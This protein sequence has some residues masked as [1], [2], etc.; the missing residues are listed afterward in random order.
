MEKKSK[1]L[2]RLLV[3]GFLCTPLF[4]AGRTVY[5]DSILDDIEEVPSL[6]AVTT[7]EEIFEEDTQ[8]SP[9]RGLNLNYGS[10]RITKLASNKLNMNGATIAH[11]E[12]DSLE[13][14]FY[15]ERKVDG[16]YSTYKNLRYTAENVYAMSRSINVIVPKGTYRI[17]GYHAAVNDGYRESVTTLTDGIY[18]G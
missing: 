18:I 10:M 13:L 16:S 11:H 4:W 1:Y 12:C 9:T 6:E 7:G 14:Y 17:R 3:I 15:L 5:A 2:I 8:Y